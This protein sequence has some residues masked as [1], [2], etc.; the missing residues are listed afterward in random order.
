METLKLSYQEQPQGFS[1]RNT[2]SDKQR[3]DWIKPFYIKGE[4]LNLTTI[5]FGNTLYYSNLFYKND[6]QTVIS[7]IRIFL[8]SV[9]IDTVYVIYSPI[10]NTIYISNSIPVQFETLK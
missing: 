3:E 5:R 2:D 9:E 8:Y 10:E 1:T 4:S 7:H 6:I